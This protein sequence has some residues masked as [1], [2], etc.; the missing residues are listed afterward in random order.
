[1]A[2]A[3]VKDQPESVTPVTDVN[4]SQENNAVAESEQKIKTEEMEGTQNG[5]AKPMTDA[6]KEAEAIRAQVWSVAIR[7]NLGSLI[8]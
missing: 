4:P 3:I 1:M 7:T 6:E 8:W 2:D 5:D